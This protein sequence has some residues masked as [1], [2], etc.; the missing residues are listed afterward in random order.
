MP[1]G[2]AELEEI[3]MRPKG[4]KAGEDLAGG[5]VARQM[6]RRVHDIADQIIPAGLDIAF[7]QEQGAGMDTGMHSK[8]HQSRRHAIV[9]QLP[10]PLV[11]IDGS[12]CGTAT[13]IL[14]RP[15]IAE[16]SEGTVP[17]RS[18]H[19]TAVLGHRAMP[20]LP[21]LAQEFGE[22][23]RLQFPAQNGGPDEVRE[24]HRQSMTLAFR[25]RLRGS[26]YSS[27]LW[28]PAR[29]RTASTVPSWRQTGCRKASYTPVESRLPSGAYKVNGRWGA[30]AGHG[31]RRGGLETKSNPFK[32]LIYFL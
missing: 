16:H 21:Q 29:S 25:K 7:R 32:N 1:E 23:L 11:N 8:R 4:I 20:D 19:A 9:A 3:R 14:A 28:R 31:A 18:D 10:D 5:S 15:W 17:L 26:A 12:F 2:V 22:V 24:K 6:R 27:S 13:V 30:C